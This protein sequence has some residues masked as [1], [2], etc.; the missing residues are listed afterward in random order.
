MQYIKCINTKYDYSTEGRKL[1]K[2]NK[3]LKQYNQSN[4]QNQLMRV[5]TN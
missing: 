2:L 5:I 4:P 1:R 3:E